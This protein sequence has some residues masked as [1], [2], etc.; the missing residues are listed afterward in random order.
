V[1]IEKSKYKVAV[2][3]GKLEIRQHS[4]QIVAET[5]VDAD[6]EDAGNIAF[7][8]LFDYISG[9]K[10]KKES[11]SMTALVNQKARSEKNSMTAPVNQYQSKERF[12]VS[13]VMPSKYSMESLPEPLDSNVVL[14]KV[15][16]RKLA[17]I[18]Y[19]GSWSKKKYEVQK[20]LLEEFIRNKDLKITGEA[21][22]ARYDPPFQ[23]SFLK[24]NEVLIPVE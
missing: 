7:R 20:G 13:F 9:N 6:F 14:R 16:S 5:V 8:R 3:E 19:S 23:L 17:V 1:G 22:F 12:T 21:I 2:K 4:P 24:R 11:I 10:Q 15:P 18:R